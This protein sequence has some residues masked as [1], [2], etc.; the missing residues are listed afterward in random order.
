VTILFVTPDVVGAPS[1]G[2]LVCRNEVEA[3]RGLG[4]DVL[5]LSHTELNPERHSMPPSP[6]LVDY[7]ALDAVFRRYGGSGARPK[8]AH[9]YSGTFTNTVRTLK[10]MGV[11]VTHTVAAHDRRES[12]REFETLQ[13]AY[14]HAHIRDLHTWALYSEGFRHA[15]L[16]IAPSRAS[17]NE[18]TAGGCER[19]E[20]IPHGT[21]IPDVSPPLPEAFSAG[22]LGQPGPDKGLVYLIR[23]WANVGDDKDPLLL[24]GDDSDLLSPLVTANADKGNFVLLGRVAQAADLYRLVSVYVQPSVTEGFGIEILEAM[25]H[26]RPVIVSDG[27]GG[28]DVVTHGEDGFVVPRRDPDAIAHHLRWLKANPRRLEEMGSRAREKAKTYTWER[29]RSLYRQLWKGMIQ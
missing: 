8:L 4:L 11:P 16:L 13:G 15:D 19:I 22:Y 5:T 28:A 18:L 29:V 2:G 6:F 21:E 10:S 27:A 7:L 26:G 24:A 9:F 1:G 23:A 17:A 3:L 14:P 25:A 12:I 20:I